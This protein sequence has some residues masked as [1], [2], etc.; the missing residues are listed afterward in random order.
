M[1]VDN[2]YVNKNK[3]IR[4]SRRTVAPSDFCLN[5][6]NSDEDSNYSEKSNES[7]FILKDK[8]TNVAIRISKNK[9]KTKSIK[10]KKETKVIKPYDKVIWNIDEKKA[11]MKILQ[12]FVDKKI[13]Y[14]SATEVIHLAF[15]EF[16]KN[17]YLIIDRSL[18]SISRAI[19]RKHSNILETL[20]ETK[21]KKKNLKELKNEGGNTY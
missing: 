20:I 4:Q 5:K 12:S 2:N 15:D 18:E 19:R 10:T 1:S 8:S 17:K 9:N 7:S 16:K 3:R 13:L 6:R 11:L 14:K 21:I